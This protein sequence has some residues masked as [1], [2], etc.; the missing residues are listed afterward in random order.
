MEKIS[1]NV[2]ILIASTLFL[3][4]TATMSVYGDA[5]GKTGRTF[6][7]R[8]TGCGSCHG[9]SANPGVVV[10]INGPSAVAAGQTAT[11]TV[12]VTDVPGTKGGV[13]I[14]VYYGTLS[15]VSSFLKLSN[16]ELTHRQS[17]RSYIQKV[18]KL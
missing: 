2:Y 3:T 12:D 16:G 15:P 13:D 5:N 4:T 7:T 11:Y 17:V 14:A 9:S 8:T 1:T 18:C 6:K 10:S